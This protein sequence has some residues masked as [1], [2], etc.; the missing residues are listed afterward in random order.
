MA[1]NT[2]KLNAIEMFESVG[3]HKKTSTTEKIE[4]QTQSDKDV[5]IEEEVV[6]NEIVKE[7]E[8]ATPVSNSNNEAKGKNIIF[9]ANAKES[10]SIRKSFALYPSVERKLE[11]K[12]KELGI[13]R[14]D[15]LNQIIDQVL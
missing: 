5:L 11:E 2:T 13:S 7:E 9:T 8:S 3:N 4:P 14:N 12:A 6:K 1:K 15:L 10:K